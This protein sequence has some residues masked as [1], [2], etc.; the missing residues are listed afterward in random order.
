MFFKIKEMTMSP[1]PFCKPFTTSVGGIGLQ[2]Y[3]GSV[4]LCARSLT[5]EF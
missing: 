4:T 1:V 5:G 3:E 2:C